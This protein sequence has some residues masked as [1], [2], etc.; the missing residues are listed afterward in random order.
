MIDGREKCHHQL[1]FEPQNLHVCEKRSKKCLGLP[2]HYLFKLIENTLSFVLN[3]VP[4][5]LEFAF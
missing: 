5:V 2:V 3:L 4:R 1:A